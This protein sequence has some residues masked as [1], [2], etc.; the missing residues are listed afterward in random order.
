[1]VAK[2]VLGLHWCQHVGWMVVLY[3][4][5]TGRRPQVTVP[6]EDAVVV[7]RELARQPSERPGLYTLV[8]ALLR[9]Q[10]RLASISLDLV[11]QTPRGRA[12][13][14]A[15]TPSRPP[16]PRPPA[17]ASRWSCVPACRSTP[18]KRSSR[19]TASP[20]IPPRP[21]CPSAARAPRRSRPPSG[22]RAMERPGPEPYSADWPGLLPRL[23]ATARCPAC[24]RREVRAE[25]IMPQ[26]DMAP[27]ATWWRPRVGARGGGCVDVIA[28]GPCSTSR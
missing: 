14:Y 10:P 28:E 24:D 8:A 13:S 12:W 7:G 5:E 9:Q 23:D 25:P 1:M 26:G 18:T 20:T 22:W 11:E 27:V 4:A 15:A 3:D 19:P 16:T 17:M 21:R 6:A 2:S